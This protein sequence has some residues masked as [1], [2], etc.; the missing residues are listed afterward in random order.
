MHN[1]SP[2]RLSSIL[3][4]PLFYLTAS[5]LDFQSYKLTTRLVRENQ[6]IAVED[7]IPFVYRRKDVKVWY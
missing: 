6:V 7:L 2:Q 3:C 5:A 4:V 1:G